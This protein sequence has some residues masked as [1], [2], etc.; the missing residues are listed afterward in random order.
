MNISQFLLTRF[1]CP[2]GY[3]PQGQGTSKEWLDHRFRLFE[4]FCLP[5]VKGQDSDA[6]LWIILIDER[7][8]PHWLD[9]LRSGLAGIMPRVML[10]PVA[11]Y[12][13]VHILRHIKE[14]VTSDSEIIVTTRLDNDDAISRSYL[15]TILNICQGLLPHR[16]YVINFTNGCKAHKSGV[17]MST[18]NVLNPF[19]SVMSTRGSLRTAF[20]TQHTKMERAGS[21][22]SIGSDHAN[23]NSVMWMQVIHARNVKNRCQRRA[24]PISTD[25]IRNFSIAPNWKSI[26]NSLDEVSQPNNSTAFVSPVKHLPFEN[27]DTVRKKNIDNAC[28]WAITAHFN[29]M[30]YECRLRNYRIFRQATGSA[31]GH[32]RTWLCRQI[33]AAAWRR[34]CSFA[35][36]CSF[37]SLAK[38]TALECCANEGAQTRKV[39]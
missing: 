12:S 5:S 11:R 14:R 22:V 37:C 26:L 3:G 2:V 9:R 38:R 7:T 39:H 30:N 4:S 6:F 8:D 16:D 13:N 21:V 31:F 1:N 35:N 23:L 34:R 32:G 27:N 33:R 10:I 36:T 15:S 19:L 18:S 29:P 28:L 20:H 24:E 17:Y 25:C